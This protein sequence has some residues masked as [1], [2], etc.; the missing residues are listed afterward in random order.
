MLQ[1]PVKPLPIVNSIVFR[2]RG[3]VLNVPVDK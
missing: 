3:C 1:Q 2:L